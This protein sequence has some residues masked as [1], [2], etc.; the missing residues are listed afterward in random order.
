MNRIS[1]RS[2]RNKFRWIYPHPTVFSRPCVNSVVLLRFEAF[3][4]RGSNGIVAPRIYSRGISNSFSFEIITSAVIT[5][6][7]NSPEQG[8]ME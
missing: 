5:L 2:S 1:G 7:D 6:A 8:E 4:K 3:V